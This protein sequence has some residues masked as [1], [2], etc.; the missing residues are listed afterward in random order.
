M[1]VLVRD[2]KA[3]VLVFARK[4]LKVQNKI[5]LSIYFRFLK[6]RVKFDHEIQHVF[7]PDV[8]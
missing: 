8:I 7:T 4:C 5:P 6:N 2:K 3:E 1:N